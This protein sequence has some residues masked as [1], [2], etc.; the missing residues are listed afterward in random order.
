MQVSQHA[1]ANTTVYGLKLMKILINIDMSDIRKLALTIRCNNLEYN[2]CRDQY[3]TN[4][5]QHLD[6]RLRTPR[7]DRTKSLY[8]KYIP[9]TTGT[10]T[11]SLIDNTTSRHVTI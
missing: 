6:F 7:L 3:S 8:P 4:T 10:D 2:C 9:L 5:S 11:L 1:T